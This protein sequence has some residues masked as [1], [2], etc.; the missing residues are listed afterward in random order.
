MATVLDP[1]SEARSKIE[2][3]LDAELCRTANTIRTYDFLTGIALLAIVIFGYGLS[4]M[5]LDRSFELPAIIRQL[6]FLGFLAA[7]AFVAY[8]WIIRPWQ[9]AVNPRFAA[10]LVESTIPDAKNA[11]I[12][13]VDLR[14]RELPPSV[15]AEISSEAAA[16]LNDA[17]LHQAIDSRPLLWLGGL[18]LILFAGIAVL[19]LV[20]KPPQFFSLLN[21]TFLPFQDKAIA[22]QTQIQLLIPET[23]NA[24][25]TAGNPLTIAIRLLGR[26]PDTGSPEQP[27][28][29]YRYNLAAD[30]E[31]LPLSAGVTHRDWSITVPDHVIQNG[32]WY[33]LAAGDARTQEFRI[34]VQTRPM[35]IAYEARYVYPNYLRLEPEIG[36]EPRLEAYRGTEVTLTVRANRELR[37]GKL[38]LSD[39]IQPLNGEVVGP[40]RDQLRFQLTLKESGTYRL[41]FTPTDSD[42]AIPT[43]AYPIKVLPDDP[44][45][46]L[47]LKPEPEEI[48]LPAN[49]LLAVDGQ[50][51]DDFGIDTVTLQF[52]LAGDNGQPL[53]PRPYCNGEQISF[54]RDTDGSYPTS[55]EVKDSLPLQELRT[56]AGEPAR[57][58]E[59]MILEYWLEARDNCTVPEA[60]LGRSAIKRVKILAP[61][62]EPKQQQAQQ[63]AAADRQAA[64]QKHRQ[65]QA[66]QLQHEPREPAAPLHQK[67]SDEQPPQRQPDQGEQENRAGNPAAAPPPDSAPDSR[68]T[69][70]P[71]DTAGMP[72]SRQP[73]PA[74]NPPMTEPMA[75]PSG[76]SSR[77]TS[78]T[79][80]KTASTEPSPSDQDLQEKA[81]QIDRAIQEQHQPGQA[82]AGNESPDSSGKTA[83]AESKSEPMPKTE[84]PNQ[85]KS[86]AAS[87]TDP[88][89]AKDA[90]APATPPEPAEAK[91]ASQTT[92]DAPAQASANKPQPAPNAENAPGEMKSSPRQDSQAEPMPREGSTSAQ[93][94]AGQART[95]AEQQA[96]PAEQSDARPGQAKPNSSS[97]PGQEKPTP[98]NQTKDA[99]EPDP[100]RAGGH[101]KSDQPTDPAQA[102]PTPATAADSTS[103][104]D[105][106]TPTPTESKSGPEQ[107]A[108]LTPG[109]K[110]P[111][112]S[113]PAGRDS[114]SEADP[115]QMAG[116]T[117]QKPEPSLPPGQE[118]PSPAAGNPQKAEAGKP[119]RS[120]QFPP[121]N[122]NEK[123]ELDRELGR[124]N[125]PAG[126]EDVERLTREANKLDSP[127]PNERQE[128]EQRFDDLL[129]KKGREELQK[130][131]QQSKTGTPEQRQQA[132]NNISELAK[133]AANNQRQANP[134]ADE[135]DELKKKAQDLASEDPTKRAAAEKEFDQ[136]LGKKG[137]EELQKQLQQSKTG[138]P[139]QRQQAQN[140]INELAEQAARHQKRAEQARQQAEQL[141]QQ[142]GDLASD[143]PN[144]RKAAEEKFDQTLGQERRKQLQQAMQDLKSN[145]PEQQ[146]RGAEKLQ[147]LAN[148]AAEMAQ[149][150]DAPPD[151]EPRGDDI[152][153]GGAGARG[154]PEKLLEDDPKNRLKTAELQ[155]ERFEKNRYNKELQ[156]RLGFTPEE[157]ERFLES[158]RAMVERQRQQL[159]AQPQPAT[160]QPKQP[161]G[162]A[163]LKV[164]GGEKVEIRPDAN[165]PTVGSTGPSQAPPGFAEAQKRFAEEAAKLRRQSGS[166]P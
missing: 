131:L 122:P 93:N 56:E 75:T 117:T 17:D 27:R 12:N 46:V 111:A 114:T 156:N 6:G 2:S 147:E 104:P 22:S 127:D 126:P 144:K 16:G 80:Q 55:L 10:R 4:I 134:T 25:I 26:V 47:I 162:P 119:E 135:I 140:N 128:A 120:N 9:R 136:H 110:P 153:P 130:Q 53:Q 95:S 92:N 36:Y 5:L 161:A 1:P 76:E 15:R 59:G 149:T 155:L 82:R 23:G 70:Q 13:W 28:L 71:D 97:N 139:E 115:N 43:P 11:V 3:Q 61:V 108:A 54:R 81:R 86:G 160:E 148:K 38:F 7:V 88:A 98:A 79:P 116:S 121:P 58:R 18:A 63:Q 100:K 64:D 35:L 101:A 78:D 14:D 62:L 39:R 124:G 65:Q 42:T 99:S 129:G 118:K 87:G 102:K 107:N 37:N 33:R 132:Q 133:K 89:Q 60:N 20:C 163:T 77:T 83:T 96:Q 112:E 143:D 157:Y 52:R 90:P 48:S 32:F 49:G 138:T 158:Y 51:S 8:R 41:Q 142:A 165:P 66:Q 44:P 94:N 151:S 69:K 152:R 19:F 34:D 164:G 31:Q 154:M 125:G 166:L 106:H 40:A 21:R 73:E 85:T 24:T 159:A 123:G 57:L 68:Q 103:Q 50:V 74:T 146:Q 150:N 137:R 113:K 45:S 72:P 141:A 29:E 67:P 145:N 30:Y 109:Q 91:P 105:N 84:T